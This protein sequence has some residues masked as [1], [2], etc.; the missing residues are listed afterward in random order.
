M[1]EIVTTMGPAWFIVQSLI[2]SSGG[3]LGVV[4]LMTMAMT[5][6][7]ATISNG[8]TNLFI[9]PKWLSQLFLE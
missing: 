5:V 1:R 8:S 7:I 3:L 4:P 9:S 2:F 6:P